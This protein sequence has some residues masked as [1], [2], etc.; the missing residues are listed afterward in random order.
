VVGGTDENSTFEPI[1]SVL[2]ATDNEATTR[3]QSRSM[4]SELHTVLT[5]T[6]TAPY[7]QERFDVERGLE[8]EKSNTIQIAPTKTSDGTILVDW[9]TTDD[10]ANPQN[11]TSPTKYLVL[12]QMAAYSLAVYG[13]TSMYVPSEQAVMEIFHVGPAAAALGLAI[14]VV[15]YGVG[16]LIFAPLSEIPAIGRNG[17]YI[18]TLILFVIL[19]IPTALVDNYAGL[20]VLRFLTGFFGSPILANG[21]ATVADMVSDTHNT[22][23]FLSTNST[24]Y[25]LL[26]LPIYLSSWVAAC[27]WG[28]AIG[29]VVAGYAVQ[30]KGWRWGLW[31]IV[32]LST[33]ILV[34]IRFLYPETSADNI[35]R[36]RAQ[37]LRKLTGRSN[38]KSKSEIEQ[39]QLKTSEIFWDA[40]IKPTEIMLKD[41]GIF[42]TNVYVSDSA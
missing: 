2:T 40:L 32:W 13:A 33:P 26:E 37:R 7:T 17:V 8:I 30:A 6:S 18:P 25:S 3:T 36:R 31:E 20:L 35:L 41:P 28:P 15:G 19:S 11:W 1:T 5:R 23:K 12:L 34:V 22:L 10:P 21:G 14:Y 24:Q 9:Y 4:G 42:F 27:F 39:E 16:P 38:I 29:P